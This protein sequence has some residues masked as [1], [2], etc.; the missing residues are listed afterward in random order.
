MSEGLPPALPEGLPDEEFLLDRSGVTDQMRVSLRPYFATT[1]ALALAQLSSTLSIP[2]P[3]D[4]F[5]LE[6]CIYNGKIPYLV[7]QNQPVQRLLSAQI[8]GPRSLR[9]GSEWD[10]ANGRADLAISGYV[11]A[12]RV[13][14]VSTCLPQGTSVF[15]T[16]IAGFDT[17][18][19]DLL[20]VYVELAF[21]MWKEK[22]RVGL[23]SNKLEQ[24]QTD[25]IRTLPQWARRTMGKYKRVT[26]QY[27]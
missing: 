27:V 11:D 21:L 6:P 5:T 16:Y 19:A 8:A 15:L 7:P 14:R 13:V 26:A 3:A 2:M 1:S 22:D 23:K 20:E 10:M 4:T 12:G 17:L 18:P 9:I 24:A 25:Y